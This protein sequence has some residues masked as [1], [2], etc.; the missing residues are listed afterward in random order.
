MMLFDDWISLTT[1]PALAKQG[2]EGLLT[3]LKEMYQEI[4]EKEVEFRGEVKCWKEWLKDAT[5]VDLFHRKGFKKQGMKG[6]FKA[7][8]TG[9]LKIIRDVVGDPPQYECKVVRQEL[10]TEPEKYM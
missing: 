8:E 2:K 9:L 7:N 3:A 1:D 5:V 10:L 6:A 4:R